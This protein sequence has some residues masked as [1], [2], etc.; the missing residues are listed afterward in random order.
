[1]LIHF[2]NGLWVSSEI[3]LSPRFQAL[4]RFVQVNNSSSLGYLEFAIM[5]QKVQKKKIFEL[6]LY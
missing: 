6:T 5:F 4:H 2:A 1:M 3:Q